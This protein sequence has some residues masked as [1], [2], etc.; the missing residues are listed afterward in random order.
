[1]VAVAP[2]PA[3]ETRISPSKPNGAPSNIPHARPS[4]MPA[5]L[6]VALPATSFFSSTLLSAFAASLAGASLLV[7]GLVTSSTGFATST[8]AASTGF[9]S[10]AGASGVHVALSELSFGSST[11]RR[12]FA[13]GFAVVSSAVT[14]KLP[15]A[16]TGA[17]GGNITG[18]PATKMPSNFVSASNGS[19]AAMMRL[20]I[21][22]ASIVP[23]RASMPSN[24]AGVV[25]NAASA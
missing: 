4:E 8:A 24:F 9:A 6:A 14:V 20:A 21:F 5:R 17:S 1:M 16:S 23:A 3:S 2:V 12:S 13:S 15:A 25:V 10:A 22:P 7:A 11:M 18:A 19:P